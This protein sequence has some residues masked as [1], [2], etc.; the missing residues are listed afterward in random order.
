MGNQFRN[1]IKK[2]LGQHVFDKITILKKAVEVHGYRT[3]RAISDWSG[4]EALTPLKV[5]EMPD[6]HVFF[7]YYDVPQFSK[8]ETMLLAMAVPLI[9]ETPPQGA[10]ARLGYYSLD[11]ESSEFKEF[12][13]SSTWC[14][15]QGCRLQWYPCDCGMTVLYN[16]LIDNQYRCVIQ[17]IYSGRILRIISR[18]IYSVSSDGKW[19]LSLDF[20]RLQRLRPGYGYNAI[21]DESFY[22]SA[23]VGDGIWRLDMVS[24]SEKLLF[25]I[26]DISFV[27]GENYETGTEHYFNHLLF[28][29][30][31]DRFMFFHV[32][33]LP[34]GMRKIRLLTSNIDGSDINLINDSGHSSHY[35][36][37]DDF[38]L[39]CYGTV[40]GKGEGYFLFDIQSGESEIIGEG[41]LDRDGHPSYLPGER[42]LITDTYPDRYGDLSL[43]FFDINKVD[44]ATLYRQYLP[45]KFRAETRCDFHPRISL[46]GKLVCIDCIES[47]KRVMKLFDIGGITAKSNFV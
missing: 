38:H 42:Y 15:Q 5:M 1:K 36:W 31:C 30:S 4:K 22:E 2:L 16:G 24:G 20:S 43:L 9:N 47:G 21:P 44:I 8:N 40:K 41:I 39:L 34:D 26:R 19:G 35:Y 28:N 13:S 29:R 45:L 6:A 14:W 11:C 46:S 37:K 23:P 27:E 3:V 32:M 33:Q 18:P 7:G 25:S 10:I 17:D 12:G